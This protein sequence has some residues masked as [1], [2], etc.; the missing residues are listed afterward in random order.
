[1]IAIALIV[2]FLFVGWIFLQFPLSE[3]DSIELTL[4]MVAG[5]TVVVIAATTMI[6]SKLK[7]FQK[8]F[9]ENKNNEKSPPENNNEKTE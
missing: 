7:S 3:H 8:L 1:M 5:L 6:M 9:E 2:V 4:C